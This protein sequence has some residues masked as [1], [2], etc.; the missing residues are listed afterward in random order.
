MY[1]N[2]SYNPGDPQFLSV[3]T[4]VWPPSLWLPYW[5]P[6]CNLPFLQFASPV[7]SIANSG[8]ER[9]TKTRSNCC[10]RLLLTQML[11]F[12]WHNLQ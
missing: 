8:S 9:Q 11:T 10:S 6:L 12:C 2:Y 4:T 3:P 1:V 7:I 5:L